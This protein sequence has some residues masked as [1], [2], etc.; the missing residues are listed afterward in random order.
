MTCTCDKKRAMVGY[1][2]HASMSTQDYEFSSHRLEL[3]SSKH[4]NFFRQNLKL[5]QN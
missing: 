3:K 1:A 4:C 5:A 2:K